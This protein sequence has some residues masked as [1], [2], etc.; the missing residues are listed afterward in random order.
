[1]DEA[2]IRRLELAEAVAEAALVKRF[3]RAEAERLGRTPLLVDGKQPG[4]P[5]IIAKYKEALAEAGLANGRF[6]A[7]LDAYSRSKWGA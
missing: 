3:T 2:R 7:A 5:E 1:M 6:L 4:E